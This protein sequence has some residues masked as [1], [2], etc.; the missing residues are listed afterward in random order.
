M[1]R[2]AFS[3]RHGRG[4]RGSLFPHSV[5]RW[6]S[7]G[8]RFDRELLAAYSPIHLAF[9]DELRHLDVA[10]DMVPRMNVDLESAHLS[11]EVASAGRI[12]LGRLI[13]AGTDSAGNPT[14]PRIV[15]FRMPI[16]SRCASAQ[17]RALLLRKVLASLVATYLNVDAAVIDPG[18]ERDVD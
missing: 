3:D 14:R 16:E 10:V 12:P 13:P 11:D 18:F 4:I 15:V 7:R 17:E 8:T 6:V 1:R 5:P 2:D 9:A